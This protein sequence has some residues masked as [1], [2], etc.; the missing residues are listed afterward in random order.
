MSHLDTNL[1]KFD[2]KKMAYVPKRFVIMFPMIWLR[3][4]FLKGQVTESGLLN[5]KKKCPIS[6]HPETKLL[7]V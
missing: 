4:L 7:V 5:I 6:T 3:K 1:I 2:L